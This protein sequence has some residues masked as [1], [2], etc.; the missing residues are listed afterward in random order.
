MFKPFNPPCVPAGGL[1]AAGSYGYQHVFGGPVVVCQELEEEEA[2][3]GDE[4]DLKTVGDI[5]AIIEEKVTIFTLF[6]AA[7]EGTCHQHIERPRRDSSVV[8][9]LHKGSLISYDDAYVYRYQGNLSYQ[10]WHQQFSTDPA[11][12]PVVTGLSMYMNMLKPAWH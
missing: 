8:H 10:R 3:M 12:F 1:A 11:Y 7:R 2:Y 5:I 4:L 9:V 6:T